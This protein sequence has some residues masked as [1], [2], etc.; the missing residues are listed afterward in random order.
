MREATYHKY[1]LNFKVPGGT[2]RGVLK[3]KET[4]FLKLKNEQGYGIGECGLFKGL[5]HDDRPD[6]EEKLQWLCDHIEEDT[7]VLLEKLRDY[8]SIQFGLEQALLSLSSNDPFELFPSSFS[9]GDDEIPINGL[10]WMGNED[11]MMQQIRNKLKEGFTTLKMKIGA[12]NFETELRILNFIRSRFGPND[13]ELRVDANGAFGL[14][15]AMEK[16]KKLSVYHIHSIEQ[17]VKAGQWDDMARLCELSPV[18]VAL[19]EE[20]I[21]IKDVPTKEKLLETIKPRF[22]ILK[23]SLVGGIKGSKEWITLSEQNDIG[24]WITSALES[25]IGLNAIAQFV[26]TLNNPMPQGLGTGGLFTNNLESPLV[27]HHGALQ[28]D[29]EKKW[30]DPKLLF[31]QSC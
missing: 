3:N 12:L 29:K 19:D 13:L 27:V 26:Y 30:G 7:N 17:P 4:Y 25:N 28:I 21:G 16:L 23:P 5:S 9:R 2:S 10:I 20:L 8:P 1:L 11:F 24:W 18:A 6:Y 14:G 22:I 15:E 31:N